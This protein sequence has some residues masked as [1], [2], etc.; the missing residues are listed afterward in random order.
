MFECVFGGDGFGWTI[1]DDWIVVETAGQLVQTLAVAAEV[2]LQDRDFCVSQLAH[3][4]DS[5][6]L[7]MLFGDPAD[8][9]NAADGK[10]CEERFYLFG[11]YDEEAV[12]LPPVG[13]DFCEEFIGS[14]A[15]RGGEVQFFANLLRMVIATRVAVGRP[16]LFSVTSR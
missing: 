6:P 13:C 1:R 3:R 8:S 14:D 16:I 12:G 7:E 11:L 2:V 4:S 15:G 10:G 5:E 9:G